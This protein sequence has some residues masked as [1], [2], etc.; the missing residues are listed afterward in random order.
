MI[1]RAPPIRITSLTATALLAAVATSPVLGAADAQRKPVVFAVVVGHNDGWGV[2]PQLRYAD[3]D[4]LRFYQ[5]A[6][7]LAPRQNVALLTELDVETWREL[8]VSGAP[9]PPFLPPTRERV[10]QV[11]ELFKRQIAAQRR[12]DAGRPV[13]L[14]FFF[15]G[16][17]ERGYFLLKRSAAAQG[18]AAGFTGDDLRRAFAGSEATLNGLFIDACKSQ[19]LFVSKGR[20]GGDDEELGPD[21]SGLMRKVDRAAQDAPIGVLTSTL[22]DRP[23]G[24]AE[25]I[26]GGYFSHVLIS[27]LSGAADANSDGLVRYDELAA[28]VAFH[29]RRISGQQPWFRPPEGRLHTVLVDVRERPGLVEILPGLGGHFALFDAGTGTLRREVHKTEAQWTRLILAPGSYRAIWVRSERRG[30][31]APITVGSHPVRLLRSAFTAEVALGPTAVPRGEGLGAP[32]VA[33]EAGLQRFDPAR[34]GFDQPFTP[35]IVSTLAVAYG[36]GLSATQELFARAAPPA[37]PVGRRHLLSAGYGFFAPPTE[38]LVASHGVTLAY[39]HALRDWLQVGG[40]GAFA[41]SGHVAPTT[42]L[43]FRMFRIMVAAEALAAWRPRRWLEL[44]A[45][46]YA[47]WQVTMITRD[48]VVLCGPYADE[49]CA[50]TALAGD[51]G[52][53]RSGLTAAVRVPLV[54]GLFAE[55][56]GGFGVELVRQEQPGG[57]LGAEVFWRPH[58]TGEIGYAF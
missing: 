4:A 55:L 36:S 33:G 8:Q 29:T 44:A 49:Q 56:G 58:V 14:F 52:G 10:L 41:Y 35:R 9:P 15:S 7:Q 28:F 18:R 53:F 24:E 16:H 31:A 51:A 6:L 20:K 39:R 12:S 23:A 1:L 48:T 50:A 38:P 54:E 43:P 17:G 57:G 11:V 46:L 34:S 37:A 21:F 26:R 5:L 45:G 19:S 25:D 3:D 32:P 2:L 47:G 42:S 13:H 27:G 30:L 22:S 40:R